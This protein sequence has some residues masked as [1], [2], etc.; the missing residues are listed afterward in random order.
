[1]HASM[2]RVHPSMHWIRVRVHLF[3]NGLKSTR[4]Q[5]T[6]TQTDSSEL[7]FL[8]SNLLCLFSSKG[9]QV[10][11]RACLQRGALTE[12]NTAGP[13]RVHHLT[14][15]FA[16]VPQTD[17]HVPS[18]TAPPTERTRTNKSCSYL[19][20]LKHRLLAVISKPA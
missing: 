7:P 10:M 3:I 16:Q 15:T 4:H 20:I 9:Q 14:A 12:S 17:L 1:M 5:G 8:M 6:F 2:H 19:Q 13:H 18:L 11:S